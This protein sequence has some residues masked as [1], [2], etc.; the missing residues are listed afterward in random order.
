MPS[1]YMTTKCVSFQLALTFF[2]SSLV[3]PLSFY[4]QKNSKKTKQVLEKMMSNLVGCIQLVNKDILAERDMFS[5]FILQSIE[6]C[7]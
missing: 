4:S 1:G 2:N 7:F 3:V 6:N 5:P